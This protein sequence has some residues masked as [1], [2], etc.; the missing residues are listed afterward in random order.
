ML[1]FIKRNKINIL[2]IF[3][4]L[5]LPYIFFKDAFRISSIIF[6]QEQKEV[7]L[8]TLPIRQ[9]VIDLIKN[10]ELPFWNRYILAGF[11]L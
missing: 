2:I 3:I 5:I 7:I 8:Q 1:N 4:F 9:L 11:P 10:F 6:G